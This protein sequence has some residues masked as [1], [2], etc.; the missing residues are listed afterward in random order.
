MFPTNRGTDQDKPKKS[1]EILREVRL[2]INCDSANVEESKYKSAPFFA[3]S[4]DRNKENFLSRL[5]ETGAMYKEL[6]RQKVN[7]CPY[8]TP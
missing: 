2:P 5:T 4:P 1:S 6:W 3:E 8:G 7:M